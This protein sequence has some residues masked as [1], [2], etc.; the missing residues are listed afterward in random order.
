MSATQIIAMTV[1]ALVLIGGAA[2][3]GAGAPPDVANETAT[4]ATAD[5]QSEQQDVDRPVA[6]TSELRTNNAESV[7]PSDGLPHQAADRVSEIH[8]R[9]DS[10][11]NNSIDDLGHALSQLLSNGDSDHALVDVAA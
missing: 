8:E 11:L 2:A 9:I 1:V 4:N 6:N 5:V 10:F 7:G 3:I